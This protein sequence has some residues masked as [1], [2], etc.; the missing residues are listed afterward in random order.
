[1]DY[2]T[3]TRRYFCPLYRQVRPPC[4]YYIPDYRKVSKT[5]YWYGRPLATDS[6]RD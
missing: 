1:M 5:N 2:G 6:G 4:P 3:C